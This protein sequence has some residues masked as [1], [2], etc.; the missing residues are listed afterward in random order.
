MMEDK[1]ASKNNAHLFNFAEG[2]K[3]IFDAD[4]AID[5]RE[6]SNQSTSTIYAW[7]KRGHRL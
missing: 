4:V 1:S 5:Y 3:L 6:E 2:R 7:G